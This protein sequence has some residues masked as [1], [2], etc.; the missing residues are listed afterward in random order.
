MDV[1]YGVF[2]GVE[3]V[4]EYLF[5][6]EYLV[7]DVGFGGRDVEK[8]VYYFVVYVLVR[9]V[10][11]YENVEVIIVESLVEVYFLMM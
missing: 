7:G 8:G 5:V 6:F 9:G 4:E 11:Y 10:V 3:D 2:G 1:V